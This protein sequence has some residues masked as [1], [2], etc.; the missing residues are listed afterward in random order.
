MDIWKE[1]K[2]EKKPGG[3]FG[4]VSLV[5]GMPAEAIRGDE[6][7]RVRKRWE[8]L[9]ACRN[10]GPLLEKADPDALDL[11]EKQ[12]AEYLAMTE[13]PESYLKEVPRIVCWYEGLIHTEMLLMEIADFL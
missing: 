3:T 12:V 8:N 9:C 6:A 10:F 2:F 11:F 13:L 4:I 5:A 1:T 7:I